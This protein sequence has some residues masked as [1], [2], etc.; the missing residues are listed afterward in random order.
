MTNGGHDQGYTLIETLVMLALS[1]LVAGTATATVM[2]TRVVEESTAL[3]LDRARAVAALSTAVSHDARVGDAVIGH[4]VDPSVVMWFQSDGRE[5]AAYRLPSDEG[6]LVAVRRNAPDIIVHGL[7]ASGTTPAGQ[8][9]AVTT[10]L[11]DDIL[12]IV[13]RF[14]DGTRLALSAPRSGAGW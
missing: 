7:V 2:V 13:L 3:R 14:A 5:I 10:H 4:D 1:G 12:T 11:T 6:T 9:H 8:S